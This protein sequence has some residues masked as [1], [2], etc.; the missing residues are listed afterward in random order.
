M[1][2][3][4]WRLWRTCRTQSCWRSSPTCQSGTGSASPGAAPPRGGR[5]GRSVG[6]GA[7]PGRGSGPRG[8]GVVLTPGPLPQGLSPL[9]E[10]GGRPVALATCRPDAVHGTRGRPGGPGPRSGVWVS[11]P[12]PSPPRFR[13]WRS[14]VHRGTS[15]LSL[16]PHV[17]S[18]DNHVQ[19]G[20]NQ[21]P[22]GK[23]LRAESRIQ[24][25]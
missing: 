12:T 4:S 3:G 19:S 1:S 6:G 10:A 18:G 20:D 24:R 17:Q 5:A 11:S 22:A 15:L 13:A 16:F 8:T 2:A 14:G 25:V 9:E 23:D 7:A 21:V